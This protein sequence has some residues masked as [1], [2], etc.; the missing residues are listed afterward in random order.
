MGG[1]CSDCGDEGKGSGGA[2]GG[3]KELVTAVRGGVIWNRCFF[4]SH[5][6]NGCVLRV[7]ELQASSYEKPPEEQSSQSRGIGSRHLR[8]RNASS[9]MRDSSSTGL[10]WLRLY[11]DPARTLGIVPFLNRQRKRLSSAAAGFVGSRTMTVGGT[12]L[13]L[14]GSLPGCSP[15]GACPRKDE[16]GKVCTHVK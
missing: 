4:G 11:R 15:K 8:E 13:P 14:R 9:R 5:V 6:R 10:S 2:Q 7:K 16:T 1:E 12:G 3:R